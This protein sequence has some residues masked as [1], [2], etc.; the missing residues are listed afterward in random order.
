VEE[1]EDDDDEE[2]NEEENDTLKYF[3]LNL[4]GHTLL[5]L[6]H[7]FRQILHIKDAFRALNQFP[8]VRV[9]VH[10]SIPTS[11]LLLL[12]SLSV[13]TSFK[14]IVVATNAVHPSSAS[15]LLLLCSIDSFGSSFG[16][17]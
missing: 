11:T 4:E 13:S 2:E 15:T 10:I 12:P 14:V 17:E 6:R 8:Q 16:C 9:R 5:I 3:L 7:P 1:E